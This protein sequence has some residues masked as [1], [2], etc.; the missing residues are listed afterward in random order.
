MEITYDIYN[1]I[2]TTDLF[3]NNDDTGLDKVKKIYDKQTT[4]IEKFQQVD[5]IKKTEAE[6]VKKPDVEAVKKFSID[7]E[8]V[9]NIILGILSVVCAVVGCLILLAGGCLLSPN[10][11]FLIPVFLFGAPLA[12]GGLLGFGI[13]TKM[14]F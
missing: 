4:L 5:K 9:G 6:A 11:L 12:V 3:N 10:S 8:L 7:W 14:E 2:E 13:A 1:N